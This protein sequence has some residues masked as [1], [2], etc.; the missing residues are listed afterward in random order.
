MNSQDLQ[1]ITA[2]K[3]CKVCKTWKHE[4]ISD[5]KFLMYSS[6]LI[7]DSLQTMHYM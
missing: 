2:T 3:L 1:Y 5:S 7:D 6:V 4:N